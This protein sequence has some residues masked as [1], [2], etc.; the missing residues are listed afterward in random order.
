MNNFTI[1]YH[2]A[3]KKEIMKKKSLPLSKAYQH[4]IRQCLT[5]VNMLSCSQIIS[6]K[7]L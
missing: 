6:S 1:A 3:E 7:K 5:E 4:K 2:R